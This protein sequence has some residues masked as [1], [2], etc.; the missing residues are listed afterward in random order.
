MPFV[1]N[2]EYFNNIVEGYTLFGYQFR[3]YLSL[4]PVKKIRI[5]GGIY[6]LRDFGGHNFRQ[7][8]PYL[9]MK[10]STGNF[11]LIFGNLEGALT[12]RLTDPVF[13]FERVINNRLE[14]GLQVNWI[15]DRFF[16]D[17]WINWE[18][19]IQ[20]GDTSQE[21]FT[22]G[23]STDFK[24]L[25]SDRFSLSVPIQVVAR[26]HG[27]QINVT[28]SPVYTVYNSALG[29]KLKY[30]FNSSGFYRSLSFEGYYTGYSGD[31][32]VKLIP[33]YKG[34]GI[35]VNLVNEF[36]FFDLYITYWKGHDYYSPLG[37]PIYKSVSYNYAQD[38]YVEPER[39]L[40]YL[41]LFTEWELSKGVNLAFRFEPVYDLNH[42]HLD[43][44]E[45]LYLRIHPSWHL[46]KL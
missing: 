31:E 28:D 4:Y 9:M 35:L 12:H 21:I 17:G 45:S 23:I 19:F 15:S 5:D 37:M 39:S 14:Q 46:L 16:I 11:S 1:R 40:L 8:L 30:N 10:Y 13:D 25:H 20:F 24:L 44:T 2:N 7:V 6:L 29:M 22:A 41:R 42:Q 34:R 43:H 3:P 38:K 26:H 36:R 32:T 18:N 33:Y 27:G